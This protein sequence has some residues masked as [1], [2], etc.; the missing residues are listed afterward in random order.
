MDYSK[1]LIIYGK[2][3][4]PTGDVDADMARIREFYAGVVGRHIERQGEI[5]IRPSDGEKIAKVADTGGVQV[6][7]PTPP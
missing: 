2:T 3:L 5:R 4:M 7:D 1:H 6:G